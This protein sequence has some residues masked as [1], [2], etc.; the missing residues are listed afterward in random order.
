[1]FKDK[2]NNDTTYSG[3]RFLEQEVKQGI[4]Q[5]KTGALWRDRRP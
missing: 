3:G 5:L 2:T 1:M 4:D